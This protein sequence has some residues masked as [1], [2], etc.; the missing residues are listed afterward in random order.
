MAKSDT[1]EFLTTREG[2]TDIKLSRA[3]ET[4]AGKITT[5]TMREPTVGDQLAAESAASNDGEKEIT[6]FSN[7]CML[8]PEDIKKLPLRDYM[9]LQA[10]FAVFLT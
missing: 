6:M 1:P 4:S 10:G 3:L 5:I 2:A 9:R 8:T 7:L